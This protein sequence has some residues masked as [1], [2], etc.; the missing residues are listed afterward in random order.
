MGNGITGKGMVTTLAAGQNQHGHEH[1]E[2]PPGINR[3]P[4]KLEERSEGNS[5]SSEESSAAMLRVKSEWV[6]GEK[7]LKK[8]LTKL[9]LRQKRGKDKGV[10]HLT[11]WKGEGVPVW[12]PINSPDEDTAVVEE[13][14]KVT[15][16]DEEA[17]EASPDTEIT[18]DLKVE[19]KATEEKEEM[20]PDEEDDEPSNEKEDIDKEKGFLHDMLKDGKKAEKKDVAIIEEHGDDETNA[21]DPFD[22]NND[23]A[24]PE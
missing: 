24:G 20:K 5:R 18:P 2:P 11:R 23:A 15:N 19:K 22:A 10:Q 4:P 7:K 21:E 8:E 9:M 13:A 14:E 3:L 12:T 6:D 16:D 1:A 17:V